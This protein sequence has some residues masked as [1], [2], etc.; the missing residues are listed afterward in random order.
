MAALRRGAP[1]AEW[2]A[3][4]TSCPRNADEDFMFRR[5]VWNDN[6]IAHQPQFHFHDPA[7]RCRLGFGLCACWVRAESAYSALFVSVFEVSVLVGV[8]FLRWVFGIPGR[9]GQWVP[10]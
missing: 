7:L 4:H 1:L 2:G 8:A 9:F 6:L 3:A 10:V 5:F